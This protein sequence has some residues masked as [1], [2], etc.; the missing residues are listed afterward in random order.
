MT[1]LSTIDSLEELWVYTNSLHKQHYPES[2]LE[3]IMAGGALYKP[4]YM[5]V[6]INP[7]CK[8]VSS[9]LNWSGKRRPW[10]G[11]KYIWKIFH[12]AGLFDSNLLEE[13]QSRKDW[14]IPFADKVYQYLA[15]SRFYFT[16][17]VKWTGEN[18]DLPNAEKIKL[19]LPILLREIE[20]VS[21]DYIVTFGL[22]PF[23]ALVKDPLKLGEY[24]NEVVSSRSIRCYD[25]DIGERVY[26]VIPSYFPV[27]RG[28][29]KRAAKILSMLP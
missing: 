15:D 28:N 12:A 9:D 25:L 18:A 19:F 5:F 21:P 8:N 7:T 13:I 20:L 16:N 23:N 2:A 22:I 3:P 17:I 26:K 24:F 29:P 1:D 6:F 10:I 4:R 14:D 27:G 11:T